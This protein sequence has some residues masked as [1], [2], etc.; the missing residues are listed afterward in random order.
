MIRQRAGRLDQASGGPLEALR[1]LGGLLADHVRLE[2]RQLFP[3]IE[4]ALPA[5]ELELLAAELADAEAD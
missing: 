4:T 2:E 3:L 1:E 5:A